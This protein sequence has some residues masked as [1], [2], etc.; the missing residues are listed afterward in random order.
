MTRLV[1]EGLVKRYD[2]VSVV[3]LDL[4]RPLEIEA[5]ELLLGLGPSGSGKTTLAR[6]I[7]GLETSD[8]GEIYLDEKPVSLVPAEERRIGLV[9]QDDALWPHLTVLENVA[10]GLRARRIGGK[11][12]RSRLDE[13]LSAAKL[14][15]LSDRKPGS[16][17]PLQR[18][19]VAIA[20]ALV[21]E[22]AA[23]VLDEP[24][25]GLED[26]ARAEFR[27]EI[28]NLISEQRTTTLLLTRDVKT[29]LAMAERLAILDLGRV[30]QVGTSSEVYNRP[31]SSF[32][33]KLLGSVNL[34]PGQAESVDV[35]GQAIVRTPLG[36]LIGRLGPVTVA[37]GSPCT[38]AIRP[39]AL[40]L[41]PA[42]P[43]DANRFA[44]TLERQVFEGELRH[45]HLR[46]PGDWPVHAVTLQH[47]HP[48]LREGQSMTISVLPDLVV[49]LPSTYAAGS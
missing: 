13:V 20:R 37:S 36:R 11:E 6:L 28:R 43:A 8:E 1:L 22:P 49:V 31:A 45:V 38:V 27:D 40:G 29:A 19:R 33:A 4:D 21:S 30:V 34:L 12:R 44:A 39:E 16:L 15:G 18:R 25:E 14:D 32:V 23:L 5:G 7:A 41:G 2:R 3:D 10:F 46:G 17:S 26:R 42:I 24:F 48:N 35:R 9:F 47:S